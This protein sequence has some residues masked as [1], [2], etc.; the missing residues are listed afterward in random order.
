MHTDRAWDRDRIAQPAITAHPAG[1]PDE[2]LPQGL[3]IDK[4]AVRLVISF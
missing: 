3:V 4:T 2:K 1:T